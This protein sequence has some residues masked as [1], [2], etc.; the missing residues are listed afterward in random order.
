[1]AQ[2]VGSFPKATSVSSFCDREPIGILSH[3]GGKFPLIAFFEDRQSPTPST[4][5]F[6]STSVRSTSGGF[7]EL[8]LFHYCSQSLL[9]FLV[10]SF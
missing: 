8:H 5:G 6:F 4:C 10:V 7:A 9:S 2:V 1:M 3:A